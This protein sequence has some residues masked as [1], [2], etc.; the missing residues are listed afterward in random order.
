MER[1]AGL[2][3][4]HEI[5]DWAPDPLQEGLRP[6]GGRRGSRWPYGSMT[7]PPLS[8][9]VAPPSPRLLGMFF[10]TSEKKRKGENYMI[11][12]KKWNLSEKRF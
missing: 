11:A 7:P 5:H 8:E 10:G 4:G 12:N 6:K 9:V 2:V 3:L 1:C